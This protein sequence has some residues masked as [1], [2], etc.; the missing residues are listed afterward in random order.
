VYHSTLKPGEDLAQESMT[1]FNCRLVVEHSAVNGGTTQLLF[2]G[3][4][5]ENILLHSVGACK[6]KHANLTCLP[7]SVSTVLGLESASDI[8]L[9]LVIDGGANHAMSVTRPLMIL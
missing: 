4:P 8:A 1:I 6:P 9:R 2:V 7:N 3:G 5:F